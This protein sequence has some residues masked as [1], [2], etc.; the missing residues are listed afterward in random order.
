M[1]EKVKVGH[2]IEFDDKPLIKDLAWRFKWKDKLGRIVLNFIGPD[3]ENIPVD[4]DV[5]YELPRL[6][7]PKLS[8]IVEV[9]VRE[10]IRNIL[11]QLELQYRYSKGLTIKGSSESKLGKTVYD[12]RVNGPD[13]I[14]ELLKQE[15]QKFCPEG[16]SNY[17]KGGH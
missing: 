9:V 16:Q 1:F 12:Q 13:E 14:L 8:V 11:I 6:S 15:V 4:L 3:G 5:S 7:I 10:K 17:P 2:V